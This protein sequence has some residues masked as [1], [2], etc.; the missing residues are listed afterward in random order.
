MQLVRSA[1]FCALALACALGAAAEPRKPRVAVPKCAPNEFL[2]WV[3]QNRDDGDK[4][5]IEVTPLK[6]GEVEVF[7]VAKP[8]HSLYAKHYRKGG[9]V[10]RPMPLPPA[11]G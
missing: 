11:G 1:F 9:L 3:L 6:G 7:D 8:G 2:H 4:V 5:H 10:C